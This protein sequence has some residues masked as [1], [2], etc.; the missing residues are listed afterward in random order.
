[1]QYFRA[2]DILVQSCLIDAYNVRVFGVHQVLEAM[3]VTHGLPIYCAVF[4]ITFKLLA[5]ITRQLILPEVDAET[6]PGL[7]LI[8]PDIQR[9]KVASAG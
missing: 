6:A 8:L 9:R 3:E 2:A 1:M 4:V 5:F 7:G